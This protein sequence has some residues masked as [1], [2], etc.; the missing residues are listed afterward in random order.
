MT[1]RM[2]FDLLTFKTFNDGIMQLCSWLLSL[3]C[4]I[5]FISNT[6]H[7]LFSPTFCCKQSWSSRVTFPFPCS[8]PEEACLL[9]VFG[10]LH[11]YLLNYQLVIF[12]LSVGS[13][14]HL[15]DYH[16]FISVDHQL[17]YSSVITLLFSFQFAHDCFIL[18]VLKKHSL[19]FCNCSI[20]K[21]TH[22]YPLLN[23]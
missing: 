14:C 23:S 19:P 18:Q 11:L 15:F 5:L 20:L 4:S 21:P 17:F 6:L 8:F 16:C 2:F 3:L 12:L 13:L 7:T 10:P 9:P 22:F 1:K